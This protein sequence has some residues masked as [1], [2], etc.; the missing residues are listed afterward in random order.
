VA[1]G[2]VAGRLKPEDYG[3]QLQQDLASRRPI[4]YRRYPGSGRDYYNPYTGQRV[5]EHYVVRI[6]RP[7]LAPIERELTAQANRRSA[8]RTVKQ[9]RSIQQ[10]FLI[11]KQAE[12][13]GQ[14]LAQ[15]Q[16]Q[17]AGEFQDLYIQLRT[18]QIAAK[19]APIGSAEREN[20]LSPTGL[21][22]QTLVDLGRRL[23]NQ[24]FLVGM[25]PAAKGGYIDTVV[26]PYYNEL[27]G[28]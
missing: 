16:A 8:V 24:D 20:I 28:Y 21:Y 18:Q 26:V 11:K 3:R 4:P 6:Y 13:P 1:N 19:N 7:N 17:Y 9:R 2:D 12:N 27:R 5:S 10:T 25:S 22:A 15:L 23:P 14:T